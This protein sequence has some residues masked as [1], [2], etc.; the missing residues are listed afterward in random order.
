[1]GLIL[2]VYIIIPIMCS[3]IIYTCVCLAI[4]KSF[5]E[6]IEYIFKIPG[7]KFFLS[8][9]MS[10]DPLENF[11]GC[12]RQRGRTSENPTVQ[13]F[14]KNTQA[15]RVINSVCGSVSKGNCRG[16]KQPIDLE[17]ENKPLAKRR[18]HRK[19]KSK[20]ARISAD[21][22]DELATFMPTE[23]GSEC[24]LLIEL[25]CDEMLDVSSFTDDESQ[26]IEK[27]A[28]AVEKEAL[29]SHQN[30]PVKT[31]S[32]TLPSNCDGLL[33]A[34]L[35]AELTDQS[36]ASSK[37]VMTL[38]QAKCHSTKSRFSLNTWQEDMINKVLGPGASDE[39]ITNGYGIALRRQDFWTL[40]NCKWL[41]DQVCYYA[42]R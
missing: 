24:E 21:H 13:E 36:L 3:L 25:S 14:C 30:T 39:K 2:P 11:F 35:S 31:N 27:T 16:R 22:V 15:L 19:K 17:K 42:L 33:V 23:K 41:N 37:D 1:M 9:R 34:E 29:I 10:Q 26:V 6:L 32:V 12:Q 38:Y 7:V 20:L 40:N 5:L 18:R 8:E 28:T 4:V